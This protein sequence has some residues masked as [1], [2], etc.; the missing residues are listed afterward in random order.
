MA[1]ATA[2]VAAF[3]DSFPLPSIR[4][5]SNRYWITKDEVR[6]RITSRLSSFALEQGV[7]KVKKRSE[8]KGGE[9]KRRKLEGEGEKR[10]DDEGGSGTG[11]HLTRSDFISKRSPF[12]LRR[13][14]TLPSPS[15][16]LPALSCSSFNLCFL[17]LLPA[18]AL[19]THESFVLKSSSADAGGV[20][21]CT[22]RP[23]LPGILYSP[24][25]MH[26]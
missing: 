13:Q 11:K 3:R 12:G 23:I 17:P 26:I 6:T 4:Y 22:L 14:T 1:T 2:T 16:S 10:R 8:E 7:P 15:P 25:I 20:P 18:F 21:A 9:R 19:G 24:Q 5:T